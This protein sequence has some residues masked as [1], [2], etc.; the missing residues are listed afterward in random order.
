[1]NEYNNDEVEIVS[2]SEI[3]RQMTALQKLGEKLL[4]L[5]PK[6]METVPTTDKLIEALETYKRI[7]HHEG[8]RRQMQYIGKVMREEDG[9]GIANAIQIIEE[10]NKA[11]NR[12]F[13]EL[14]I[15]RDR[16]I[17]EG[18]D[19]LSDLIAKYPD[20]DRQHL[21]QLIRNAQ[22]EA[23]QNKPPA[24]ARKLFKY[25]REVHEASIS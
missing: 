14:E 11:L 7:K 16:L 13:Q 18:E 10:G 22:K 9:E 3:K 21:R 4:E 24:S 6:Q 12:A 20:V 17:S 15:W 5:S 23:S 8:R 19:A 1:M 2:K 25:L